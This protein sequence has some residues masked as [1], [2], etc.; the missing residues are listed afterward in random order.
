MPED[1]ERLR[2][3]E[4][5]LEQTQTLI[6][7]CFGA[8]LAFWFDGIANTE[9]PDPSLATLVVGWAASVVVATAL[10]LLLARIFGIRLRKA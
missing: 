2:R 4:M 3:I 9:N 10:V 1:D 8:G 5:K 6:L 7:I